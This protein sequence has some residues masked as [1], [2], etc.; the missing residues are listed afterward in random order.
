MYAAGGAF[1]GWWFQRR[2][3]GGGRILGPFSAHPHAHLWLVVGGLT[4]DGLAF[5]RTRT[6]CCGGGA[7][8]GRGE[9]GVSLLRGSSDTAPRFKEQ[10]K[11]QKRK[12]S[13]KKRRDKYS[14]TA[15]MPRGPAPDA[16]ALGTSNT[17]SAGGG[18]LVHVAT[19]Q[20]TTTLL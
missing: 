15:P 19:K 13:D 4:T 1:V 9:A 20:Y 14:S 8:A 10:A 17:S 6:R 18:R 3:V 5:A 2:R 11:S 7:A 16:A 12:G